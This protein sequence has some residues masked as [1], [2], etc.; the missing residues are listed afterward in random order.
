MALVYNEAWE[1]GPAWQ[2]GIR[3]GAGMLPA[4][5]A[6]RFN[7]VLIEGAKKKPRRN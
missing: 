7:A 2:E 6:E 5:D 1:R 4:Q 3:T